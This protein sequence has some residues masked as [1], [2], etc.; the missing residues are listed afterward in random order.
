MSAPGASN[1][2]ARSTR[3]VASHAA[4]RLDALEAA[5]LD[6]LGRR[7]DGPRHRGVA[8]LA[9]VTGARGRRW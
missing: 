8:V 6:V 3:D 7:V 2:E 4:G 9:A 5:G 1:A